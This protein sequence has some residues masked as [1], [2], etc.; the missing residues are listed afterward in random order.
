[1]E[2]ASHD[3]L[4][5]KVE[6]GSRLDDH[7]VSYRSLPSSRGDWRLS[8]SQ[9]RPATDSFVCLEKNSFAI[10]TLTCST[11]FTQNAQLLDVLRWNNQTNVRACL[12]A[13]T[14]SG[15]IDGKVRLS[16]RKF[17]SDNQFGGII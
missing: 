13:I 8:K 9:T 11:A 1:L 2:D 7:D 16:T 15:G 5:Y 14:A 12:E 10:S 17:S 3:L 6:T 4:V